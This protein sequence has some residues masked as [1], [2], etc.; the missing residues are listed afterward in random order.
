MSGA[1]AECGKIATVKNA[2]IQQRERVLFSLIGGL[3][4]DGLLMKMNKTNPSVFVES[5]EC[6]KAKKEPTSKERD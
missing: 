3:G 5:A 1:N 2:H 4:L 6:N